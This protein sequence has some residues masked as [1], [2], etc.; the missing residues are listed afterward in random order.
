MKDPRLKKLCNLLVNYSCELKPGDKIMI[1]VFGHQPAVAAALIDEVYAAGGIPFVRLRSEQV[2]RKLMEGATP[3]QYAVEAK[4]DSD[5]MRQMQA[6][7]G[8]RGLDN[9][10]EYSGVSAE[11][12]ALYNKEYSHKVHGQIRI[13]D[14]R[15]CVLRYPNNAMAQSAQM[16]TEAFEDYYFRVCTMDYAKLGQAMKALQARMEAADRVHIQ[17]PD[18]DLSFSIK[19]IPAI[20]CDGKLNIP[21]GEV[22]TAPVRDSVNGTLRYNTASLYQGKV[23]TD[24]RFV[25]KNGRIVEAACSDTARLNK[26]LD[27]DEGARSV[28]EFS[29]GVNPFVT[30]PIQDTLFDEKIAGSFH[31][32]PGSCYDDAP[33]GNQSAIHWDLVNIQ[34]PEYGGGSI[35]LDD[36]LIRKDGLFVPEDLLPLNPDAFL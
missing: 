23:Y 12:M 14:T 24:I 1:E 10:Y 29:F 22:Y 11:Q 9:L 26:I 32:T 19:G 2:T 16:S 15:W 25:F 31:F 28:G 27:T 4:N 8:V 6:Y 3:E 34:R 33:N 30:T 7:L 21:D 36:V 35:W 17:G 5:L 18:T 13:P 20:I